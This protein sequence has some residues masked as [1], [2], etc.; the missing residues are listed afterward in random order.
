[1]DTIR[2][3]PAA[4]TRTFLC[5]ILS[6]V[7]IACC[8]AA[9]APVPLPPPRPPDLAPPAPTPT[10]PPILVR[11]DDNM[12]RAQVLA[13]HRIVGEA[14]PPI[15][16]GGGCGI[17]APL[18][19][20]AVLLADGGKVVLLP[21]AVVRASLA[22]VVADWVREDLAPGIAKGDRLAGIEGTGGYECRDRNRIAGG[23]LSEHA[24][25][26]ALD[27]QAFRTEHGEVFA[28]AAADGTDAARAFLA[29]VK[30]TACLRFSTVLG[31]GSDAFHALHLHVDLEARR[32]NAHLCQWTLNAQAKR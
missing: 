13:S 9:A 28:V 10:P 26:D 29:L 25:G 21:A 3:E 19:L 6:L 31:P 8:P 15:D 1:M 14:L 23:K 17:A 12:L 20:D 5:A 11:P 18:R 4:A 24:F 32:N 7:A 22:S 2:R 16:D 30:K 27:L